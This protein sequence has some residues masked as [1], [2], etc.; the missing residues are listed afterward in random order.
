MKSSV[1]LEKSLLIRSYTPRSHI[2]LTT[3]LPSKN[4]YSP[5]STSITCRKSSKIFR[6][7]NEINRYYKYIANL[8]PIRV[9]K[10][11]FV[12][13]ADTSTND[14]ELSVSKDPGFNEKNTNTKFTKLMI[15]ENNPKSPG[16]FNVSLDYLLKGK[17]SQ[18]LV[19]K[20]EKKLKHNPLAKSLKKKKKLENKRF[21]TSQDYKL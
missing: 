8:K 15:P 13:D 20:N 2:I 17:K 3:P 18:E 7:S 9:K 11:I 14:Q 19:S 1:Q 16:N 4:R 12:C 6:N 21:P 5:E 10:T